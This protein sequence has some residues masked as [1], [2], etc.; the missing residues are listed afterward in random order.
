LSQL[1]SDGESTAQQSITARILPPH[2]GP[3]QIND[4]SWPSTLRTIAPFVAGVS[5]AALAYYLTGDSSSATL[6]VAVGTTLFDDGDEGTAL[7]PAAK[8]SPAA[9]AQPSSLVIANLAGGANF[10]DVDWEDF[11]R[12]Q[13]MHS[14]AS[15][16]DYEPFRQADGTFDLEALKHG[17]GY[18]N[19]GSFINEDGSPNIDMIVEELS[20]RNPFYE[21]IIFAVP[22]PSVIAADDLERIRSAFMGT[23]NDLFMS[24]DVLKMFELLETI[25]P[26]FFDS[27]ALLEEAM[28]EVARVGTVE[29]MPVHLADDKEEVRELL[30]S[31]H[32][33][34]P[35]DAD[36][37]AA[38]LRQYEQLVFFWQKIRQCTGFRLKTNRRMLPEGE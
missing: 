5:A 19:P 3:D 1:V 37:L 23:I 8:T 33:Y 4:T 10:F 22:D 2:E 29:K 36:R 31:E 27:F 25:F 32:G 28:P 26:L 9:D 12:V 7:V 34:P 17:L 30:Q 6:L 38:Q 21:Y 15:P 11:F 14:Y 13:L 24:G 18:M 35:E 16:R 20:K